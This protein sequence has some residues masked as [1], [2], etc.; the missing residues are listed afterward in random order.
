MSFSVF[1]QQNYK[2]F[3]KSYVESRPKGGRGEWGRIARAMGVNATMVSQVFNGDK[4]LSLEQGCEL[5]EYLNLN[6]LESEFLLLLI[7]IERAGSVKLRSRLELQRDALL[8][9][10][11]VVKNRV[12]ESTEIDAKDKAQFYS[13]WLYSACRI[14]SSIEEY[15]EAAAIAD[16]LQLPLSR[17]QQITSFLVETGMCKQEGGKLVIGD[18]RTHIEAKSL[19]V[20]THHRNWRQR[21]MERAHSLQDHELMFSA[22]LSISRENFATVKTR[23]LDCIQD[24]SELVEDSEP[25]LAVCFNIDW[26]ELNVQGSLE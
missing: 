20:A 8:S 10:S 25:E 5:A 12:G 15:Q 19:M 23:L 7:Q 6:S 2:D 1:T 3:V 11:V 26:V 9:K 21:A 14:L 24:A 22:P 4:N 13:S 18:L 16:Y 17:V